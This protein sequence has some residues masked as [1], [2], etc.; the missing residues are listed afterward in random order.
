MSKPRES[1]SKED[2]PRD[3]KG[4]FIKSTSKILFDLFGGKN[5][6]PTNPTQRYICS[7]AQKGQ[8]SITDITKSQPEAEL[9]SE[10]TMEQTHGSPQESKLVIEQLIPTENITNFLEIPF[11]KT[12]VL[13]IEA[14]KEE[15]Q[16]KVPPTTHPFNTYDNPLTKPLYIN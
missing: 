11:Q 6:P 10:S 3:S 5:T 2:K 8:S 12:I 15:V 9:Q 1:K 14:Q 13:P 4:R 16:E 7:E